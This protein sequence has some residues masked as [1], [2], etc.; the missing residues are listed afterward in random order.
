M[1]RMIIVQDEKMLEDYICPLPHFV[2]QFLRSQH[3][4]FAVIH[5]LAN[6]IA[7]SACMNGGTVL[8]RTIP[9][10][11]TPPIQM[12]RHVIRLL[13]KPIFVTTCTIGEGVMPQNYE[14]IEDHVKTGVDHIS[15]LTF[16]IDESAE[17][18]TVIKYDHEGHITVVRNS[19]EKQ[20]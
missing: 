4:N 15:P 17:F 11:D 1:D 9:S 14:D 13:G 8:V 3:E 16:G 18:S 2:R 10:I 6:H 5:P 7:P 20:Y 19:G 12:S